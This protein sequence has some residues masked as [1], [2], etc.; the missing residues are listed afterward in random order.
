MQ[1]TRIQTYNN[2]S[3]PIIKHF[4]QLGQVKQIDA[5]RNAD[6]VVICLMAAFIL[7]Y[8]YMTANFKDSR[9]F[10]NL[11]SIDDKDTTL[12]DGIDVHR[13][14]REQI[15]VLCQWTPVWHQISMSVPANF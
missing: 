6:E 7:T 1:I 8:P 4:E 13:N 11:I 9:R 2:D 15:T 14:I 5:S 3:M 10:G 12:V